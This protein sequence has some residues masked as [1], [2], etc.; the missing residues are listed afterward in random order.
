[1]VIIYQ[2]M[3]IAPWVNMGIDEWYI[4]INYIYFTITTLS[5]P[6]P[7][8]T[9]WTPGYVSRSVICVCV[10]PMGYNEI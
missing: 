3:S 7:V 2:I 5:K 4:K 8:V 10:S 9:V 1:M 6:M